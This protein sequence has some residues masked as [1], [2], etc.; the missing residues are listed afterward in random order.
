MKLGV[1]CHKLN[2]KLRVLG[3]GEFKVQEF[4]DKGNWK[5]RSTVKIGYWSLFFPR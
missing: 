5:G 4:W 2:I 1:G 3:P